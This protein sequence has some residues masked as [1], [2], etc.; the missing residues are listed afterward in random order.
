MATD[1]MSRELELIRQY[2]MLPKGSVVLCAVSGGADSVYLLEH[3]A[4]LR[5]LPPFDFTLV[6]V[7]YNHHLRGEESD[8]DEAFVRRLVSDL[9]PPDRRY[10]YGDQWQPLPPISLVVGHGDVAG[11]AKKRRKGIEETAREMRY[12]FF[13][14]TAQRLGASRILTA[15]NADDNLETVLLH[16]VRGTGLQ[17]LTGISPR[18]GILARPLLATPRGEIEE[19]LRRRRLPYVEDSTNSDEAYRRNKMRRQVLPLLEEFNP[20]LRENSIDAIR[21]LR[22]DNDYL[23]AQ[24]SAISAQSS[25]G[26]E[27]VSISAALIA[28]APDPLAIRTARQL[29]STVRSGDADCTAAHLEA[30]VALCRGADPS[31]Q[32]HL[33][34]GIT[35]RRVYDRLIFTARPSPSPIA[36]MALKPGSN[37]VP[38][39]A[40]IAVL[41]G[42]PW[43]GLVVRPRQTGDIITLA[44]GHSRSLKRLMIDKKIPRLERDGIPVAADKEGILAV[45]GLGPN[46]AHPRHE[47][48]KFIEETEEKE[49]ADK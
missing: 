20:A 42:Q 39:T 16:L 36:P 32:V 47:R 33:P 37:P 34:G 21:R 13:Y 23:N 3:L 8:R 2:D 18:Q 28:Q 25:S 17:G 35:A 38:K 49:Y 7:H 4:N 46:C 45:A 1:S 11:E 30:I 43:P 9:T 48:I 22:S 6:A 26:P 24:A 40:W 27:Q 15:H 10:L 12:A 41:E 14:E 29:L 44:N 31:G 5:L 19:Y